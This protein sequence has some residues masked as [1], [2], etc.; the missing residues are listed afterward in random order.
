MVFPK[1]QV[2]HAFLAVCEDLELGSF[3]GTRTHW[4]YAA[5]EH[6]ANGRAFR[7]LRLIDSYLPL[8]GPEA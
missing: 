1:N 7:G 6:A 8:T 4:I 5:R 3:R 2:N